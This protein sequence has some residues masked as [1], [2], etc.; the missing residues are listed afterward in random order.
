MG[1]REPLWKALSFSSLMLGIGAVM[2]GN[3]AAQI[4]GNEEFLPASICILF[5]IFAQLS[6]NAY[7]R[8]AALSLLSGE[9]Q[10]LT[11]T[12]LDKNSGNR[13]L[14]FYK[15]FSFGLGLLAFMVGCTLIMRGGLWALG[16]AVIVGVLGWGVVGG[17]RPLLLTTWGFAF[18]FILFGPVAVITTT[19]L[20]SAHTPSDLVSWFDISPALFMSVTIGLMAANANL[21]F[22]YGSY[23]KQKKLMRETFPAV[24]GRR[25]TRN[26]YLINSIL[27]AGFFI[28]SCFYL[29]LDY[30]A[31]GAIPAIL[32]F[33]VNLYIWRMMKKSP[34]YKLLSLANWACFNVLLMGVVASICAMF[35]GIPSDSQLQIF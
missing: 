11:M 21:V 4:H 5:V 9:S 29:K 15:V 3:A 20:Q 32:C 19:M 31:I 10:K 16:A 33:V 7:H 23:F 22:V 35:V 25:A 12:Q 26:L 14:L 1:Q 13:D 2:G 8:Y 34:S 27:A 17:K 6:A 28:I 30:P 18:T 24:Y